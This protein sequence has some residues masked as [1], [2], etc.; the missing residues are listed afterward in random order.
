[1]W[2]VLHRLQFD[3]WYYFRPP[4]DSGVSPPE[5]MQ[6]MADH[7]PGRAIDLGCGTG[8]NAITLARGGWQVMGIDFAPRAIQIARGKTRRAGVTVDLRVGDV[9]TIHGLPGPFDLAL[10][11][12]CFHGVDDRSGYLSSL[13]HL[14]VSGGHWLMYGFFKASADRAG[15]GL[16][17]ATLEFIRAH[18]FDLLSRSD[19][20]DKRGRPSAW[21]LYQRGS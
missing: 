4:W 20:T 18:H 13:E 14:V 5:L 12:G 7:R 17:P 9:T 1:M 2:P 3:L 10:D 19:G 11:I 15:P 21:F 16:D 8:T 6:F